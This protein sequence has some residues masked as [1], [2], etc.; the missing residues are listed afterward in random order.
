MPSEP[1]FQVLWDPLRATNN[2]SILCRFSGGDSKTSSKK[3]P[4]AQHSSRERCWRH[5]SYAQVFVED[6]VDGKVD[7]PVL[8]KTLA[9]LLVQPMKH[10]VQPR[11]GLEKLEAGVDARTCRAP[12]GCATDDERLFYE[13]QLFFDML[14]TNSGIHRNHYQ[15]HILRYLFQV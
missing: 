1:H 12:D 14:P 4:T 15:V 10:S 6:S 9:A 7:R 2:G 5:H 3:S 8:C 11:T 13:F